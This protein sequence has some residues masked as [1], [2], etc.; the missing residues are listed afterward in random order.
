MKSR[1]KYATIHVDLTVIHIARDSKN[2]SEGIMS[3]YYT[4]TYM[5][6]KELKQAW[7]RGFKLNSNMEIKH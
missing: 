4:I 6:S 5:Y 3:S 1:K 2:N 7:K